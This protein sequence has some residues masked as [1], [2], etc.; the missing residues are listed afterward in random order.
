[1]EGRVSEGRST[2]DHGTGGCESRG[3]LVRRS[4]LP[5]ANRDVRAAELL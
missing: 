1:M 4:L 5:S 3:H 2:R